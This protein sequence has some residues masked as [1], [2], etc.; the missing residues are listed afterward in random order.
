MQSTEQTRARAQ[1]VLDYI[2]EHPERHDQNHWIKDPDST[3]CG[4]SMCVAGTATWLEHGSKAI[5]LDSEIEAS[6]LFGLSYWE[7]Q[8]LFYDMDK[9]RAVQKLKKVVVGEEFS[10][11]DFYTQDKALTPGMDPEDYPLRFNKHYW[12]S[13]VNGETLSYEDEDF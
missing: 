11:E 1:E 8:V 4:T 3:G 12:E 5:H 6:K 7:C 10:K 13:H 2:H 9:E